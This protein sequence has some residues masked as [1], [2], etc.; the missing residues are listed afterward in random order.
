MTHE[1]APIAIP[2]RPSTGLRMLGFA[3]EP[4]KYAWLVVWL[5]GVAVLF[6]VARVWILALT[7]DARRRGAS[8]AAEPT[9]HMRPVPHELPRELPRAA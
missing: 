9:T 5:V 7:L 6:V 4:V 3:L 8:P 1:P 2:E